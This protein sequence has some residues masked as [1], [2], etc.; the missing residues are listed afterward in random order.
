[1]KPPKIWPLLPH[2]LFFGLFLAVT[3]ARLAAAG[4]FSVFYA[5]LIAIN[6]V[7]I[8]FARS[9]PNPAWQ[10][11]GLL[12]YPLAMNA[13]FQ[14]LRVD[15]P[16]IH[17]AHADAALQAIDWR[18]IGTNLSV[19]LQGMT[20]PVLTE[21]FS[22][23]YLLF[24]PY[25]LFTLIYYFAGEVKLLAKFMNGLFAL[26][27][28]GFLGYTLVPATGPCKAMAGEFSV[29][30]HGWL[31]SQW[32]AALVARGSIGADV[33]PSLHCAVSSYI[34]FFDLRHRR[35]RFWLYLVPCLLLWVSTIYLRYHYFIDCLCGFA[36]SAFAL[37]L[38]SRTATK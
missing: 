21:L 20:R 38:A 8:G 2:E 5:I 33:F 12:F 36:L 27:G 34:L 11:V 15:I 28:I 1:M 7:A 13:A 6:I 25:L 4:V 30:L 10:R 14:H 31:F 3:W 32:N 22:F 24:F 19:R 26:Y 35:W 9:A 29:P 23:C 17:P 37:W 16:I 18:L